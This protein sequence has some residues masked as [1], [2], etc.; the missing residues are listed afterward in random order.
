MYRL[1]RNT[2]L[3]LGISTLFFVLMYA[4]SSMQMAHTT[5]FSTQPRTTQTALRLAPGS[6]ARAAAQEL[7]RTNNVRGDLVQVRSKAGHLLFRVTRPGKTYDIDYTP[8]TGETTLR[9]AE[10]NLMS[11]LNRL[12]HISGLWHDLPI[13][14]VWAIFVALISIALIALALSGIYLWFKLHEERVIG[15]VLLTAGLGWGLGLL[16]WMRV[17]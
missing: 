16:L 11:V 6:D 3:L 13:L 8:A 5:W 12:H 10:G 14:N 4:I 15:S 9:T 17:P 2:H 1:I 7:W